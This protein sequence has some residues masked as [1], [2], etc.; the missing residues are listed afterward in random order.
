MKTKTPELDKQHAIVESG[1]TQV[2]TEFYDWLHENDYHLA[3]FQRFEE[4]DDPQL[5]VAGI[6]PEQ[7]FTDFFGID[8]NK[9]EAER[10]AL[11][12]ELRAIQ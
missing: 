6:Q 3:K 10:R 11:L 7:L 12:E 9:I 4:Y 2:L 1:A 8:R 5:V